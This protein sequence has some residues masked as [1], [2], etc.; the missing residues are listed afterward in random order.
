MDVK[1]HCKT[2]VVL[3]TLVW[4]L[5]QAWANVSPSVPG[6]ETFWYNSSQSWCYHIH[7]FGVRV[8]SSWIPN[9]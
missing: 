9:Y 3:C 6:I 8:W 4:S 1:V 5:P 2:V 7:T